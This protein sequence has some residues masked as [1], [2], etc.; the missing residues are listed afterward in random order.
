MVALSPLIEAPVSQVTKT[1]SL[2]EV[3]ISC[4]PPGNNTTAASHM[5]QAWN[6]K[7]KKETYVQLEKAG[8]SR[9]YWAKRVVKTATGIPRDVVLYA[10]RSG[11]GKISLLQT[12]SLDFQE[13]QWTFTLAPIHEEL[14]FLFIRCANTRWM[15]LLPATVQQG[16]PYHSEKYDSFS[17]MFSGVVMLSLAAGGEPWR[18]L[19]R[20]GLSGFSFFRLH[21][22]NKPKEPL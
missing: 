18:Y 14:Q 7:K 19:R 20:Y 1:F 8:P 12:T 3:L 6:R 5:V 22:V 15:K 17:E 9:I 11:T 2:S 10:L 13:L 4:K 21:L 16:V